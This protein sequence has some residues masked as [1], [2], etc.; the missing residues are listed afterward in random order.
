M[1][2]TF[3][4]LMLILIIGIFAGI[5]GSITG[6]GGGTIISPILTIVLEYPYYLLF[7]HLYHHL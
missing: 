4:N 1:I 3:F 5:E 7:L 2:Y 6:L